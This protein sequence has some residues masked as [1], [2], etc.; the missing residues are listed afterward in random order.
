MKKV[1]LGDTVT[2]HYTGKLEN[3]EV[4]DSS[5]VDGRQPLTA[6]LG[7]GQL[8][9]GFEN[10]LIDMSIG[11]KKTIEIS[12]EDAYGPYNDFMVQEVEKDKMPGEVEVGISLQADTQMGPINFIVREVKEETVVLDANH[13]L[14]GEKLI[15]DLELIEIQ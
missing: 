12:H 5:M 3:G 1:Q 11:D 10:G 7:E 4:F 8:I 13:P 2:V 9:K 6:K 15:F 14:A